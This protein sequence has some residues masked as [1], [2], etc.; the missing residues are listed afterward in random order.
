MPESVRVAVPCVTSEPFVPLITPESVPFAPWLTVKALLP[1]LTP[2]VPD[3]VLITA[4][5]VVL[6]ISKVALSI[7]VL[8]V[9]SE[10][11]PERARVPA[12]IVVGPV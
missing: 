3:S 1:R 10:L 8:D 12:L 9:T 2:P 4:P 6:L 7:R 5:L 11:P